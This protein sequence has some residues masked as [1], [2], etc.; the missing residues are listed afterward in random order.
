MKKFTE[1]ISYERDELI[2]NIQ[3]EKMNKKEKIKKNIKIF[4]KKYF[5]LCLIICLL[6]LAMTVIIAVFYYVSS[7]TLIGEKTYKIVE[8]HSN[9]DSDILYYSYIT[10]D[11]KIKNGSEYLSALNEKLYSS[12]N[13]NNYIIFEEW[14]HEKVE[15]QKLVKLY[16]SEEMYAEAFKKIKLD[17]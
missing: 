16:V 15:R 8:I 5:I 7:A 6:L 12:T 2:R 13:D 9:D 10:E 14:G 11:N 1:S 4:F 17:E 3:K